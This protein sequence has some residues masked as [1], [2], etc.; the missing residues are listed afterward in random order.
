VRIAAFEDDVE[1]RLD[2]SMLLDSP[3]LDFQTGRFVGLRFLDVQIPQG[4]QVV[5][6]YVKFTSS[7]SDSGLITVEIKGED[8]DTGHS[9]GS[10]PNILGSLTT[11]TAA[12]S[13]PMPDWAAGS[14]GPEQLTPDLGSIVQEIV[15]RPGWSEF[16]ALVLRFQGTSGAAIRKA[17]AYDARPATAALLLIDYLEASPNLVQLRN[18]Q[19]CLP[20]ALNGNVGGTVPDDDQLAADCSVRVQDTLSGLAMA[21]HYP[22]LC[23][24]SVV[25]DS[26]VW[27]ATC[28][29]NGGVCSPSEVDCNDFHAATNFPGDEPVCSANSPL[30]AAMFGRRTTCEVEGTAHVTVD[31]DTES[32]HTSGIIEFVGDPCYGESCGVGMEY[33]LDLGSV[34][35]GNFF[36]SETFDN[37]AGIGESLLG[38]EAIVSPSGD[39][40]FAPAATAASAQGSRGSDLQG[41]TTANDDV[42]NVR[43]GWAD[44]MPTCELHGTVLGTVDPEAMRCENAGPDANAPCE[45]DDDCTDDDACSDAVCNCAPIGSADLTLSLDLAGDIRNRPPV[46]AGADQDVECADAAVTNV[47]LDATASSDAD[48]NIVLYSWLKGGLDGPEVAFEAVSQVEQSLGTQTYVLRVIDAWGQADEDETQVN[49]VDT[50]PPVVECSVVTSLVTQTNHT[51]PNVGLAGSAVDQCEGELPVNITVFSDE[52]DEDNTGD[53]RYSPDAKDIA[54]GS[55]RLRAERKGDGDGRVYLIIAAATDSSENRGSACCSVAVPSSSTR[56]ARLSAEAQAAAARD[57]CTDHEGS[58]PAQFH[59]IGDGPVIG[60]KQ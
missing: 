21:C 42:I 23:S 45:S 46:A 27:S 14:A 32:S 58:A 9:F 33:R 25:E 54:V 31:D 38:S 17:D 48:G 41:L 29:E 5:S 11:T 12:V 3:D 50:T 47:M 7:R 22:S 36:H 59:A 55:L 16:S 53:G 44:P 52:D 40:S 34:T 4:A 18:L 1:Q 57:Y 15:D 30:A 35:F 39:G 28:D 56:A 51:L 20:P 8:A 13:W 19:V 37:L 49:V 2:T 10:S 43:L 60:P 24:C 6:A 26:R